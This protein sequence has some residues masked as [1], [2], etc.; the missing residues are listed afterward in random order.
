MVMSEPQRVSEVWVKN[1]QEIVVEG[2]TGSNDPHFQFEQDM[3]KLGLE[4]Q[5]QSA[6]WEPKATSTTNQETKT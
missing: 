1:G 3:S 2:L 6:G 5:L 4:L